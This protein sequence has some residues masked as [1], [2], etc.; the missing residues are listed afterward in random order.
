MADPHFGLAPLRYR[1]GLPRRVATAPLVSVVIVNYQRW[2]DT[3]ALVKQ[4]LDRSGLLAHQ[5][6]VIVVDNASADHR[7]AAELGRRQRVRLI[8]HASNRG[9]AAAVNHGFAHSR[10]EWL[11]VLN[12]DLVLDGGFADALGQA[13]REYRSEDC[14]GA[15]IGIVGFRLRNRDGSHQHSVGFFPTLA[16]MLWGLVQPRSKRK[17]LTQDWHERQAVPWVTGCCLLVRRNCF[18]EL[19]GFDDD[20]FLYYED[21]DLCRRA[22]A[23]GWAVCY[24]PAVQAVHL[25]PLQNRRPVPAPL[26]ALT[27]HAALTYFRKHHLGWQAGGLQRI[28]QLEAWVRRKIAQARGRN[29]DAEVYRDMSHI[30]RNLRADRPERAQRCLRRVLRRAGM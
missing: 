6:E 18:E 29:E 3:S 24:E 5:I 16:R 22:R 12:P 17:Y 13:V 25:D 21:V 20:F 9:F 30:C 10:G 14:A 28:V 27:R 15:P 8:R 1:P 23:R 11:L 19:G 26:W 4:L 2:E 7:L